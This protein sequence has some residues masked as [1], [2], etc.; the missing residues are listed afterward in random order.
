[1]TAAV[2]GASPVAR[3]AL[4]PEQVQELI[5]ALRRMHLVAKCEEPRLVALTG[6][7]SSVI[8]VAYTAHG[9][10]CIKR[11]LR[12]LKVEADWF[13]PVERNITEAAWLKVAA[14]IVPSA[15]PQILGE[16]AEAMAFA[17]A[18]L[19]P[20]QY[21]VWKTQLS[22]GSASVDTARAVGSVLIAI[23]RATAGSTTI[24]QAF[25]VDA[26]FHAIRLEPYLEATACANPECANEL[27]ALVAVTASTKRALV[28]GDV[29]PKN[30]LVGPAGPVFLDAECAW[31]G[32]PAFDVAF[33]LTHLLLKCLWSPPYARL[34]LASFDALSAAY[35]AGVDWEAPSAMEA[36]TARLLPG[37]MLARIDGKSPVEYLK[38]SN[39]RERVRR[40]ARTYLVQP[41]AQL[42]ILRTRWADEMVG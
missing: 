38:S 29:S 18:Y 17:M 35:L 16:D 13:A 3:A 10:L 25:A 31:Y 2:T 8:A 21:P 4:E 7:I 9:P 41:V 32:D 5:A 28:H 39:D 33:C 36:R 19:D 30:I 12:K 22:E 40:F 24:Q 26:A 23:H 20:V 6:G 42:G 34:H 1:M 15:V 27:R 14:G 37:L 11:A